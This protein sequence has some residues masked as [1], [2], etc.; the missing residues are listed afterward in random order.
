MQNVIVVKDN[1][2][3]ENSDVV[4]HR[5]ACCLRCFEP[6]SNITASDVKGLLELHSVA[7]SAW[8]L[9]RLSHPGIMH[10]AKCISLLLIHGLLLFQSRGGF[11][12][13]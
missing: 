5:L 4:L 10:V 8:M 2:K 13:Q 12:N 3:R 9:L 11:C 7:V 6:S 1:P